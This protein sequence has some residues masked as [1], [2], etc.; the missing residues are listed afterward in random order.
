MNKKVILGIVIAV[1][2]VALVVVGILVFG[3]ANS[4]PVVPIATEEEVLKVAEDVYSKIDM[5][6]MPMLDTQVMDLSDAEMVK[7]FT[8]L[9]DASKVEF[10]VLSQPMMGSQAYSMLLVKV[11]EGQDVDVIKKEMVDNIDVRRWIC[12]A[13]EKVLATNHSDLI[14]LVMADEDRATNVYNAFKEVVQ[15]KVGTELTRVGEAQ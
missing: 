13:A 8:G 10:A 2:V 11:K 4:A 5:N 14:C 12:V 3:S 15:N 1:V 9:S 7:M 6:E